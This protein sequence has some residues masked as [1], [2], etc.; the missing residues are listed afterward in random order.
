MNL[1]F[2]L[3]THR[4][5]NIDLRGIRCETWILPNHWLLVC[6]CSLWDLNEVRATKIADSSSH[7][8]FK[9]SLLKKSFFLMAVSCQLLQPKCPGGEENPRSVTALVPANICN[10]LSPHP[11]S[12]MLPPGSAQAV[13]SIK[14]CHF[15]VISCNHIPLTSWVVLEVSQTSFAT[16]LSV[17]LIECSLSSST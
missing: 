2:T 12:E 10:K 1:E 7:S 11:E 13:R 4:S 16:L 14:E 3:K 17:Q 15:R 5:Q 9:P 6:A 8:V